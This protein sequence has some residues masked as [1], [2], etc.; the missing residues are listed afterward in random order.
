MRAQGRFSL[1]DMKIPTGLTAYPLK[2]HGNRIGQ[3]KKP[4][5]LAG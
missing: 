4:G 2:D 3:M 1:W 5:L